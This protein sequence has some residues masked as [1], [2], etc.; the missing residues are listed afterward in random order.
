MAL[1]ITVEE[2]VRAYTSSAARASF[3]EAHKGTLAPGKLADL[4]MLDRNIFDV[5]P[6]EIRNVHVVLTMVGGRRVF[7]RNT[8]PATT[9]TP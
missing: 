3:E 8:P 2:A 9:A 7:E 4:V 5:P 1:K 6:E